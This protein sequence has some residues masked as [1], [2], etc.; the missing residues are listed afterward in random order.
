MMTGGLQANLHDRKIDPGF[1]V[2]IYAK[3]LQPYL[4]D[5]INDTDAY[6][7]SFPT[8]CGGNYGIPGCFYYDGGFDARKPL[9]ILECGRDSLASSQLPDG[10][11]IIS[12]EIGGNGSTKTTAFWDGSRFRFG[13]EIEDFMDTVYPQ[14]RR[15]EQRERNGSWMLSVKG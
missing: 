8:V 7:E 11:W 5:L 10:T 12:E 14:E 13:A 2:R 15:E 6:V 1:N 9:D 4:L 3:T